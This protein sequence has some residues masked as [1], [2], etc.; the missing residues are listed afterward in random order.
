MITS[1]IT[2]G[3]RSTNTALGTC[4]PPEVSEKKA[5]KESSAIPKL[6]SSGMV[7]SGWIP[8]SRQYSSLET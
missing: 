3:S 6:S 1:S 8:C 5:L 4:L 7:P 2:V